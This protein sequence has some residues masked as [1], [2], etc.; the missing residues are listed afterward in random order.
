MQVSTN[1]S[2]E[3]RAAGTAAAAAR[4]H[5]VGQVST[6]LRTRPFAWGNP[7][8]MAATMEAMVW[9]AC[10]GDMRRYHSMSSR[11]LQRLT[12]LTKKPT[13]E[14]VVQRVAVDPAYKWLLPF[15]ARGAMRV[16]REARE[17]AF[18][19]TVQAERR[20]LQ[21]RTADKVATQPCPRCHRV[22]TVENV[23]SEQIRGGD[24]GRTYYFECS[25]GHAWTE[26]G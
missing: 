16:A 18:Q 12:R 8:I 9:R 22:S 21:R 7:R 3:W 11:A 13:G 19:E 5:I 23:G 26:G 10:G 24:E 2:V 6:A 20:R 1:L 15:T 14:R 17:A 25:C 4:S